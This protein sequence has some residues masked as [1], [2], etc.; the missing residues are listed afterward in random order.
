MK[1]LTSI[2]LI[3]AIL[4]LVSAELTDKD[5]AKVQSCQA[6]QGPQTECSTKACS[7]QAEAS[8][9][10]YQAQCPTQNNLSDFVSCL[11]KCNP[12]PTDP[13]DQ[14]KYDDFMNCLNSSVIIFAISLLTLNILF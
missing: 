10:C 6:Q 3:F 1:I 14:K 4:S 5:F 8:R 12:Y 9:K 13:A 2:F 11:K 7:D